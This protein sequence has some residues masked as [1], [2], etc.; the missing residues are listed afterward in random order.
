MTFS[1]FPQIK[2]LQK[3]KLVTC[4]HKLNVLQ[5]VIVIDSDSEGPKVEININMHRKTY[6]EG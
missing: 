3:P 5:A 6:L 4:Y 2:I 1:C